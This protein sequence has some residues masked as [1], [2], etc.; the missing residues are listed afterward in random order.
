LTWTVT[1][2]SAAESDL[3]EAIDW[4]E[5]Q[6]AGLGAQLLEEVAALRE[7]LATNPFQFPV[8]YRD[9]R[10]AS[11]RRFPYILIFRVR[12]E[13]VRLLAVFHTSR[14]PRRWRSRVR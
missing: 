4:Y 12:D 2:S 5:Q 6:S 14:N 3:V 7:R 1:A 13:E 9:A 10:R 8:L 11:L